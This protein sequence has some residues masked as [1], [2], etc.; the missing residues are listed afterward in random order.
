MI[1]Q[2]N[3]GNVDHSQ[4]IDEH[5][6]QHVTDALRHLTD[7]ITRVEV[8]LHDDNAGKSGSQD[9][10]CVM[11]ARIA[12]QQPLAVDHQNDDLYKCIGETADKLGRAVK[13]Q[14]DKL[15]EK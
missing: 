10:R 1:I 6:N 8:H 2:I 12:G 3:A 7:R 11:E 13:K 5:V 15:D 4:A 14:I 9:K